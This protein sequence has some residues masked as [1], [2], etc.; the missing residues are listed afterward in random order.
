MSQTPAK[1][2][3]KANCFIQIKQTQTDQTQ[4]DQ[5]QTIQNWRLL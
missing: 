4:T 5:T 1:N 3:Q 2:A